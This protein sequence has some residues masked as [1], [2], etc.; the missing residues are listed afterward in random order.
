MTE[1]TVN[2][3]YSV[4]ETILGKTSAWIGRLAESAAILAGYG[5]ASMGVAFSTL[6]LIGLRG[7]LYGQASLL[8]LPL[9]IACAIRFGFGPAVLAA[10]L[11]FGCWE[12]FFV[13]PFNTFQIANTRSLVSLVVFLVAATTTAHL[14]A[15]ARQK[16]SEAEARERETSTLYNASQIISLEIET[17]SLLNTLVAHLVAACNSKRS[18]VLQYQPE[19]RSKV[20]AYCSPSA[21]A[22]DARRAIIEIAEAVRDHDR[23]PGISRSPASLTDE[24]DGHGLVISTGAPVSRG[25]Y[26]PLRTHD[27]SVGVLYVGMRADNL[28][29]SL[30]DKRLILTLASHAAV[31]LARERLAGESERH[32]RQQ[33]VLEERNRIARDVHDTL[34]HAFTSIKFLLE[35]AQRIGASGQTLDCIVEARRLAMEGAQE[36][37]NSVWALRPAALEQAGG[38]AAAIR[39]FGQHQSSGTALS[40]SVVVSGDECRLIREVEENLLRVTQE[41]LSNVIRHAN[42]SAVEIAL[43]YGQADTEALSLIIKDNGSGFRSAVHA[44]AVT[45]IASTNITGFGITSMFERCAKIGAA[46]EICS[47]P[48]KGTEISITAPLLNRVEE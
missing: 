32:S 30:Q 4:V 31:V 39:R 28:P 38:L 17:E 9:V 44:G 5:W 48:N 42:A 18:A 20:I 12:F 14:A 46:L 47:E 35:A 15:R 33:A 11:S 13:P 6:I 16:T 36:A 10:V 29:F 43:N 41:A 37:R 27:D 19:L 7:V 21:D 24:F 3:P 2:V 25:V 1:P 40:F 23:E 22:S 8:Y 45:D 34:S 26:L